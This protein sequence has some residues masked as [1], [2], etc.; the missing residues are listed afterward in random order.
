MKFFNSPLTIF[1]LRK[2]GKLFLILKVL[3]ITFRRQGQTKKALENWLVLEN[4]FK[5]S[6]ARISVVHSKL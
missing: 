5:S 3:T 6:E 4:W 1:L 2:L